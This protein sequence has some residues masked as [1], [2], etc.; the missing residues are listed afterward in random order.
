MGV[1]LFQI[2]F[3]HPAIFA[4]RLLSIFSNGKVRKEHIAKL[5]ISAAI[6]LKKGFLRFHGLYLQNH[7]W[8]YRKRAFWLIVSLTE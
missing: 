5:R 7:S 6:L 8:K 3:S 2:A 1:L 4:D